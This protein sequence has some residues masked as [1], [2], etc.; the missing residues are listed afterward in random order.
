MKWFRRSSSHD[1]DDPQLISLSPLSHQY[2]HAE[3]AASCAAAP[4]Y[5]N[6]GI[7]PDRNGGD[8]GSGDIDTGQ[9]IVQLKSKAL[10][11]ARDAG[12]FASLNIKS[13]RQQTSTVPVNGKRD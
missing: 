8:D 2:P 1:D 7:D 13:Q 3:P 10:V 6:D 9:L 11:A 12:H 4:P 5:D